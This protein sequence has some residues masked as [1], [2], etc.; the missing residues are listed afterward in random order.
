MLQQLVPV[1]VLV[2][3]VQR[4]E[5][6]RACPKACECTASIVDCSYRGLTRVPF[7][8]PRNTHKV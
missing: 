1:L 4:F 5:N 7:N 6:V 8:I 2:L 3:L